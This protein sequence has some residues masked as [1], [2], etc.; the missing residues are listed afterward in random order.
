MKNVENPIKENGYIFQVSS[1]KI[2][3]RLKGLLIEQ[4]LLIFF[5]I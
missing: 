2:P 1:V 4:D 5:N 3:H